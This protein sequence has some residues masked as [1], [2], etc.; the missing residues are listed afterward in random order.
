[1]GLRSLMGMGVQPHIL[2]CRAKN[3]V[4]ETVRQKISV[5]ANVPLERVF[6]MH[7]SESIYY[8]PEMVRRCKIDQ[9]VIQVLGLNDRIDAEKDRQAWDR[10]CMFT[11]RIHHPTR[12][13]NIA[14]TGKY[15]TVRDSYASIIKALEH[16]GAHLQSKFVLN[17]IDT[18]DITDQN[19][20]EKLTGMHGIIVPGG[21]GI[22]G[23]DGKIACV[24]Y[25][26]ENRLPYLGLCY[27][28]QMA[29]VEF[30]RN[31]CKLFGAN[32]TEIDPN[33]EHPVIDRLPNQRGLTGL[34]GTMRLG[35]HDVELIPNTLAAKLYGYAPSARL[36]FRHRYE[37]HPRYIPELT[38]KGLVFSGRAPGEPIMQILELSDHPF[39][40]GTQAHPEFTS[41]PLR[42]EPMFCAFAQAVID[43]D[44]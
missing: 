31:V 44:V 14:I 20:A 29:V 43:H 15:I 41:R 21:F 22:R 32:S 11:Q 5:Y 23:T 36:R 26:R 34:G 1:L 16:C 25:A 6:S 10:W 24:R 18:T 8:I 30:A 3:P 17:W 9:E 28:F 33:C 19:V 37:V 12:Q 42:P 38:T 27:G 13:V 7:D 39:F 2:A 4:S 40:M 35:G